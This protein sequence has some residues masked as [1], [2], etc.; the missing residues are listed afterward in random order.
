MQTN[1]VIDDKLMRLALQVPG[2]KNEQQAIELGLRT[3][4]R[5][6]NQEQLRQQRGKLNWDGD[7]DAMRLD[8]DPG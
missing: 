2:V 6:H 1:F 8:R 5:L 4:I 3:L 7:L